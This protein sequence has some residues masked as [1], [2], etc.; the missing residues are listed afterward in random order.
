ME[1]HLLLCHAVKHFSRGAVAATV[2]PRRRDRFRDESGMTLL[3]ILVVVGLMGV[4]AG[5]AI[6][7]SPTFLKGAR[8]DAG[9]TQAL[10]TLRLARDTA[11][12]QRRNI[13]VEFVGLTAIQTVREDIG[14]NG[15]LTGTTT[16]RTM[17]LE[18]NMQFR[19]VP[20]LP[21]T[22]QGF[23]LS[24]ATKGGSVAFGASPTR[25]FTS[26]GTFVNQQGDFLNGT[27]FLAI[28]SDPGSARAITIF[29]PTALI[30]AWRWNGR[31]WVE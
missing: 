24:G 26:E 22:P 11:I 17:E 4:L 30:R 28:P 25:M 12:S 5:M 21:N 8:A 27:V 7:V 14:A 2:H 9:I 29:G 18:N 20:D 15:T 16:L 19:V 6:M 1:H 13:R 23:S 3:E 31:E 10:D